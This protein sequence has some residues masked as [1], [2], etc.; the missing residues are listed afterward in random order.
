MTAYPSIPFHDTLPPNGI[1][2]CAPFAL[3][4]SFVTTLLKVTE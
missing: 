1:E 3:N 4:V 2:F